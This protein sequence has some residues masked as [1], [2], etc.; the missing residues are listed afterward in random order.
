MATAITTVKPSV[1]DD[2]GVPPTKR[3]LP[4]ARVGFMSGK[5]TY[6]MTFQG[7]LKLKTSLY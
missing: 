4:R 5:L 2:I 3:H 7:I 1:K 6:R